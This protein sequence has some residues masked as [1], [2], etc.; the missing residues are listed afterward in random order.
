MLFFSLST[1]VLLLL[2][3]HWF[4]WFKKLSRVQAYVYGV[5]SILVGQAIW[6]GPLSAI[7]LQVA[8]FC[9]AG[10]GAVVAAYGYDALANR[11]ARR[12]V[13]R[14]A[15]RRAKRRVAGDGS[16]EGKG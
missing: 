14:R 10:G 11:W 3:G 15:K 8:A 6:F 4:P 1:T 9:V 2:V 13:K 12:R 5:A 16:G 7:F